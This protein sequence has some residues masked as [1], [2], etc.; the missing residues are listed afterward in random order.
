MSYSIRICKE[1]EYAKLLEF[2]KHHWNEN[3][4]FVQSKKML[5]FQHLDTKRK[6]YNFIVAHNQNTGQFD[7][8]LGFIPLNFY[9]ETLENNDFWLALWKVKE[10]CK[11]EGIGLKLLLYFHQ[12]F[13]PNSVGAIGISAAA[14]KLYKAFKWHT[15]TLEHFY[16][17]NQT[18]TT[19]TL[20][21]LIQNPVFLTDD[22]LEFKNVSLENI[23]NIFSLYTPKK[24][25]NFFL[26]RY[27]KHPFY[28]YQICGIF[29]RKKLLS[30]FVFRKIEVNGD[31]CLRIVDWLGDFV[32]KC[33]GHFL[34]LLL[35]Y[36]AQ[37]IDFLCYTNAKELV[38][39]M[40]F[41][42]KNENEIVP[43]YFEPLLKENKELEFA[44]KSKEMPY[45]IFKGDSDQ[46]RP[47]LI[48][49]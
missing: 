11:K 26:N 32:A 36:N 24:S 42:L 19:F 2:I 9:D 16:I 47:N 45:M 22:T 39:Q 27:V 35:E 34:N 20:A 4:I 46:D 14:K 44:Y 17:K 18:M 41:V 13:Q 10:E 1:N 30:L 33:W 21:H 40:G 28:K 5:D 12:N 49:E 48:K 7:A 37:Y 31:C 29:R 3:H 15:G 8:L 43:N 6:T 23:Q 38:M 25:V